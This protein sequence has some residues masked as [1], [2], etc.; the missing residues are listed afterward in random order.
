MKKQNTLTLATILLLTAVIILTPGCIGETEEKDASKPKT[1]KIDETPKPTWSF[2]GTL[3]SKNDSDTHQ[4]DLRDKP[5]G[6]LLTIETGPDLRITYPI[7]LNSNKTPIHPNPKL[8]SKIETI[9]EGGET[10][11]INVT[12]RNRYIRNEEPEYEYTLNITVYPHSTTNTSKS[13]VPI[14]IPQKIQ[15]K[16]ISSL[17]EENRSWMK[18]ISWFKIGPVNSDGLL[19]IN[20]TGTPPRST[21]MIY[22]I[23]NQ[24]DLI[25]SGETKYPLRHPVDHGNT[26]Y[27]K[28]GYS[29]RQTAP[30]IHPYTYPFTLNI[31]LV[32]SSPNNN[33]GKATPLHIPETV[34]GQ[35]ASTKDANW[36]KLDL[37]DQSDGDLI[38]NISFPEDARMN[39]RM[40]M[41]L[42]GENKTKIL[43][44]IEISPNWQH[45]F[46]R[47]G[48]PQT[49][50]HYPKKEIGGGRIYYLKIHMVE[51]HEG[52]VDPP[53]KYKLDIK[54]TMV[55]QS[56]IDENPNTYKVTCNTA[57][58]ATE[59]NT[60]ANIKATITSEN[61]THWFKTDLRNYPRGGILIV[62]FTM[63]EKT[64]P[65][66]GF[67]CRQPVCF[68][69]P[70]TPKDCSHYQFTVLEKD[71]K[72]EV[73]KGSLAPKDE[74]A[75]RKIINEGKQYYFKISAPHGRYNKEETYTIDVRFHPNK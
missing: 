27:L 48:I 68:N 8:W 46:R 67:I 11:H 33:P 43:G 35:V 21:L 54:G 16:L 39:N 22:L 26:Y 15:S 44:Y 34:E 12:H 40:R 60:P 51:K 61:D 58:T 63:P 71:R 30:K 2:K 72:T 17:D 4:I 38:I 29:R 18:D 69:V 59:V 36:F 45:T 13:A 65:R 23:E 64:E 57:D 75:F 53:E 3:T 20:S 24:T 31:K 47:G 9:V 73:M 66:C 70:R 25:K 41:E 19:I 37:T 32:P 50:G 74:T 1:R 56:V 14:Q 5:Y 10:Y 42:L 52:I 55:P 49:T 6:C 7:L 28:I 62:T